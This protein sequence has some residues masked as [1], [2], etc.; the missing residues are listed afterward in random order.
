MCKKKNAEFG[1][2][3]FFDAFDMCCSFTYGNY[4]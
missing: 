2:H 4:Y 1:Q 3:D